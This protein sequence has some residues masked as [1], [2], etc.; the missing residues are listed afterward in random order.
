[1]AHRTARE[2][3][4]DYADT[5]LVIGYLTRRGVKT[6]HVRKPSTEGLTVCGKKIAELIEAGWARQLRR[7]GLDLCAK[8][9]GTVDL[10]A[11]LEAE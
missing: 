7:R 8:C 9:A 3:D 11:P 10:D 4:H 6:F 1:M 2:K 5:D